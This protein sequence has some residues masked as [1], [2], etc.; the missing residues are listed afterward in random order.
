M[1]KSSLTFPPEALLIWPSHK[2]T[3]KLLSDKRAVQAYMIDKN[4]QM[5]DLI[6]KI[7]SAEMGKAKTQNE[8]EHKK[9]TKNN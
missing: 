4:I 6:R 2:T 1:T 8:G 3:D 7:K 5:K 9:K